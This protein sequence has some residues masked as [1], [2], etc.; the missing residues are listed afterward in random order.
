MFL[1][2]PDRLRR[3]RPRSHDIDDQGGHQG[4]QVEA[5]CEAGQVG[6]GVLVEL[7]AVMD[8]GDRALQIAHGSVDPSELG[9]C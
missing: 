9:Y 6:I 5:V 2:L 8:T 4:S 1:S 7:E 3:A